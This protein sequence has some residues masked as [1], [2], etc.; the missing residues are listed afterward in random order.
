MPMLPQNEIMGNIRIKSI[1]FAICVVMVFTAQTNRPDD[2]E[3][4]HGPA[5]RPAAPAPRPTAPA[6]RNLEP[7]PAHVTYN[8]QSRPPVQAHKEASRP[9]VYSPVIQAQRQPAHQEREGP[10]VYAV[11]APAPVENNRISSPSAP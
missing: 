10:R 6:P 1:V 8:N 4:Q 3:R 11:P 7:R 9:V 5:P 2:K